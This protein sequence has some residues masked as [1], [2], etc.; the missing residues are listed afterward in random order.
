MRVLFASSH[1]L[2]DLSS[3]A[4]LATLELMRALHE[5]GLSCAALSASK[6]DAEPAGGFDRAVDCGM[7]VSR[8]H[9]ARSRGQKGGDGEPGG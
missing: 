3:G 2:L 4:A 9:G 1:C 5:W 8:E 6:L 7:G